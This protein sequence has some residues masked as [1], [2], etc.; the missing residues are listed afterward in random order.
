MNAQF[1]MRTILTYSGGN[2]IFHDGSTE[3]IHTATLK[4]FVFRTD[5]YTR[6]I[7]KG[8]K[9]CVTVLQCLLFRPSTTQ[10]HI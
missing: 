1:A 6:V 4:D 3:R 9:K 8:K 7:M 2:V 5:D 10:S